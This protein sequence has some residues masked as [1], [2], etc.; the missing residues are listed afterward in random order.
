M[1]W[2]ITEP[3]MTRKRVNVKPIASQAV[4]NDDAERKKA[5]DSFVNFQHNLGI[6]ADNALTSS[7]YGF[8]PISKQRTL[9]EWI[10]RGSWLG[11]VG[12]DCVADDMTREGVEIKGSIEPTDIAKIEYSAV[13]LGIWNQ[14]N[15]A[16]KW[17]R[18]YGGSIVV[19]L[20]DGQDPSTPLRLSTIKKDQFA[21]II[22]FDRWQVEPSLHDL[23]S[24]YGP[25]IGL[26]RFY[27]INNGSPALSGARVHYSRVVRLEGIKLPYQQSL[28]ENL[29]GLSIIERAYDRMIA[30]DSASTGAAQLIYKSYLRTFSV[31]GLR[32]IVAAGGDAV[33]GL[34]RYVDMM[35]RFQSIEGITLLDSKDTF[36]ADSHTALGGMSDVMKLLAEQV[37]GA[38]QIPMTRL[39]GQSAGGFSSGDEDIRNYYDTISQQQVAQLL[40]G[41]TKIYRALVASNGIKWNDDTS[42]SFKSLWKTS[43]NEKADIAEKHSNVVVKLTDAGIIDRATALRE[44]QQLSKVTGVM[45]NITEEMITEA[46]GEEPPAPE[47]EDLGLDYPAS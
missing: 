22:T 46:E 18:L 47:Q 36:Q 13:E 44:T 6:G 12:V 14:I 30:F 1:Y 32:E 29:W 17:A 35:R 26:P 40:V 20:V 15:S 7:T 10:H 21:G 9:L 34:I 8:N 11:G 41:V 39:F 16:I 42:I 43:D 38:W 19:L 25:C 37:S 33:N 27:R 2:R 24:D 31:E 3:K 5:Q 28:I 45:T 4:I 23:V